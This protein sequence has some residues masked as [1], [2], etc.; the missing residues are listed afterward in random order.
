MRIFLWIAFFVSLLTFGAYAGISYLAK[1][2]HG[3]MK[4]PQSFSVRSGEN[5]WDVSRR[6]EDAGLV[7]SRYAFMWHLYRAKKLNAL[8]AGE[9]ELSGALNIPE[10]AHDVTEGKTVS[11]DIRVT[12]PEG[13]TAQ[14]MSERLTAHQLPGENFLYLVKHPLPEWRTRFD[15]LADLPNDASLEGYLFPDT[16]LFHPDAVG[17]TIIETMLVNFGKKVSAEMQAQAEKSGRGLFASITLASI[18]EQEGRTPEERGLVSDVFW[19][20]IDIGQPLQSD[21]TVNYIHGTTKLQPTFKDLESDS[22]YNT[23]RYKGLPPGPISN[24]GLVSIRAALFPERNA[25]YYFLVSLKT[26]ETV[27][28]ETFEQHVANR[29]AHGL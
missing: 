9:Y 23:Y 17:Q 28:A 2:S 12:F 1:Y 7:S 13:W 21:A 29:A 5:A 8:I 4:T 27:F 16:Y 26:G 10:I 18:V 6:L 11:R 15:F 22:P 24:P 19:K 14:K 3:D 25:Y 20:R